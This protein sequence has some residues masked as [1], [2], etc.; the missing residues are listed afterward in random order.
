MH[1]SIT[2]L[3][4]CLFA[5][6]FHIVFNIKDF[7]LI[8]GPCSYIIMIFCIDGMS[9]MSRAGGPFYYKHS[10]LFCHSNVKFIIIGLFY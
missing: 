1:A 3:L 7:L 8:G 6:K 10:L 2:Y 9:N 5:E 4:N